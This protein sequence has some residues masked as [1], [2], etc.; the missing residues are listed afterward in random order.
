[1]FKR[2]FDKWEVRKNYAKEDVDNL[3]D[4]IIANRVDVSD[5]TIHGRP[6]VWERAMRHLDE[7]QV[8]QLRQLGVPVAPP[9]R[10]PRRQ[11]SVSSGSVI[12]LHTVDSHQTEIS[13][14]PILEPFPEAQDRVQILVDLKRYLGKILFSSPTSAIFGVSGQQGDICHTSAFLHPS[15]LNSNYARGMELLKHGHTAAGR[16]LLNQAGRALDHVFQSEHPA[17][18]SCFLDTFLDANHATQSWASNW[19]AKHATDEAKKSLPATHPLTRLCDFVQSS[20]QSREETETL[21]WFCGKFCEIFSDK[22]S[23]KHKVAAYVNLKHFAKLMQVQQFTKAYEHL[24]VHVEPAFIDLLKSEDVSKEMRAPTLCY[25]RRRAHLARSIDNVEEARNSLQLAIGYIMMW[26]EQTDSAMA[27]NPVLEECFRV[28]DEMAE[29]AHKIGQQER[30]LEMNAFAL[31]I[32]TKVRGEREGKTIRMVSALSQRYVDAG[33]RD[34]VVPLRLRFPEVFQTGGV[35]DTVTHI[36]P[37]PSCGNGSDTQNFCENHHTIPLT[38]SG[39][40]L[41]QQALRDHRLR[42]EAIKDYLQSFF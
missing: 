24:T 34:R 3:F 2:R 33:K 5:A 15:Q 29:Y 17:L 25:L 6:V 8:R 13:L 41:S 37:C 30:A 42:I 21:V 32:C 1:M 23:K 10:R 7:A 19:V 26:L 18:V 38:T 40:P 20:L 28:V 11:S 4:D 39:D 9:A 31:E 36:L 16:A 12:S 22:L 14:S 35:V 27:G